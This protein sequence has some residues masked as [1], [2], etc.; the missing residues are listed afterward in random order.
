MVEVVVMEEV[1]GKVVLVE[2]EGAMVVVE[3]G[4]GVEQMEEVDV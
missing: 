4:V 1:V 3:Q 2:V